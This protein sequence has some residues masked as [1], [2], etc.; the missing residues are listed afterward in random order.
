[1]NTGCWVSRAPLWAAGAPRHQGALGGCVTHVFRVVLFKGTRS[2]VSI[3]PI[4]VS[5]L[6]RAVPRGTC[7]LAFLTCPTCGVS[8]LLQPEKVSRERVAEACHC[9]EGNRVCGMVLPKGVW[10]AWIVHS[11]EIQTQRD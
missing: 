9:H 4:P 8:I 5:L 1:M 7:S 6:L 3:P 11:L 2:R 10:L